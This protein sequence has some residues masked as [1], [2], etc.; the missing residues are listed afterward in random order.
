MADAASADAP[1]S[2]ATVDRQVARFLLRH[3]I[4]LLLARLLVGP[5]ALTSWRL[6]L[7]VLGGQG[8]VLGLLWW[9]ARRRRR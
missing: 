1:A 6:W 8:L 4:L 9:Y 2:R 3:L 5:E 7:L